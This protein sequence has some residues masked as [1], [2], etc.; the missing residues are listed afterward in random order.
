MTNGM[1]C[2]IS[3]LCDGLLPIAGAALAL[4]ALGAVIAIA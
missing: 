1:L 2:R 3:A 4:L